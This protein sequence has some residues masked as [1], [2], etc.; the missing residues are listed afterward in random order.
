MEATVL[1][2]KQHPVFSGHFP[3]MPVVPGACMVQMTRHL[4]DKY[5][6]AKSLFVSSGQVKFL[7]AVNPDVMPSLR[8]VLNVK[9]AENGLWRVDHKLYHLEAPVYKFSGFYSTEAEAN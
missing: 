2:D 5:L 6:N 3:Q 7:V 9:K 1:F 4:V 8:S